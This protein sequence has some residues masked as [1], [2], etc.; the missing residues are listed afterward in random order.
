M[1]EAQN[2]D[3]YLTDWVLQFREASHK[4]QSGLRQLISNNLGLVLGNLFQYSKT[5]PLESKGAAT[6]LI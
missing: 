5:E 4:S 2:F 3:D 1:S 6:S